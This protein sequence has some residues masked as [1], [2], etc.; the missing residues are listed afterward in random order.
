MSFE[1]THVTVL[2]LDL[3][4]CANTYSIAPCT[5]NLAAGLECYNTFK[6]CQD[7]PNFVKTT[8]TYKFC[9]TG[10]P[11]PLGEQIRP[12]IR[13]IKFAP[14][15]IDL[16][17]G[18]ARRAS[19]T[20]TLADEPVP[21]VDGDP[22]ISTRTEATGTYWTRLLARNHNYSGRFA[23]IRRA[24][25]TGAWND[26]DF[27]DELY[28]IDSIVG[29]DSSGLVRVTLKDPVKLTDLRKI[30]EPSSGKLA[31]ALTESDLSLV[32]GAGEGA[33]YDSSGYV[34][35][36]DEIIQFTSNASNVLSWPSTANRGVFNTTAAA[37]A[38][39]DL[40]QVC[41]VWIDTRVDTVLVDLLEDSG[42]ATGNIDAAGFATEEET[43]LRSAY[44]ITVCLAKPE[45]ASK[46]LTDLLSH[47][48]G[49]MWWSPADQKV[50]FEVR[51]PV[52]PNEPAA[53][54][55]NEA[56]HF[57]AGSVKVRK[58]D[59]LRTT[60]Q[61][62][63]YGLI[64][65]VA[66]RDEPNNFLRGRIFIDADAEGANE[67]NDR[68]VKIVFS[69]WF[70]DANNGAALSTVSRWAGYYRDAPLEIEAS[71]D[72]KD[73][74]IR[75]GDAVTVTVSQIVDTTGAALA[76]PCI[77]IKRTDEVGKVKL[78]MRATGFAHRYFVIAPNGTADYP[79][80]TIYGHFSPDADGFS[81]GGGPY[82]FF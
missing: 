48:G 30:P 16:E 18:L 58:R 74:S 52:L 47:I 51:A 29:P 3:D 65:P 77:V 49:F 10:A 81:D 36:K 1:L 80:D 19:V 4:L 15:E 44:N 54:V 62:M 61:A 25:F 57:I 13:D 42:I 23:R 22:Y 53:T 40:V 11:V 69:Q 59:D 76:T 5:A 9:N 66:A 7:K 75:E 20:I 71:I 6:T 12:Y 2:E 43:W 28:I 14:T 35:V 34:R 17:K 37:A 70:G 64:N 33:S 41:K 27:V 21:D 24:Y 82:L 39:G 45:S 68:R 8:K 72:A 50:K 78:L 38:I 55:L 67:Y 32:L 26:P 31:V 73:A 60:T 56:E 63:Y 46:L 79:T